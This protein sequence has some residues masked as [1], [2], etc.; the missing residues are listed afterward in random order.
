MNRWY[1]V[2]LMM[3]C[4]SCSNKPN[5]PDVSAIKAPISLQRFEQSFFT[6]DT[7]QMEESLQELTVE[8]HG[9]TQDFLFNILGSSPAAITQD[10]PVFIRTYQ[11]VAREIATNFSSLT[12]EVNEV[13][14]GLQFVKH[15]FPDYRLPEKII[16]FI[17]PLNSYGSIITQ[18]GLGIGLQLYMGSNHPLYL[19]EEGQQLYPRYISRRFDRKYIAVNAIKNIIDDLYPPAYGNQPL[20]AQMVE[21]GKR[22][23]LLDHLMPYE[24]DSIKTGYTQQQ[25]AGCFKNEKNIWSFFIQ[26]NLLFISDPEMI[27]DYMSEAPNTPTLG[28]AS[29]GFIGQFVGWQIVKK[30]MSQQK[31]PG[32][33]KMLMETPAKKI[34]EEAKYKP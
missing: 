29:P 10:I 27:R 33:M 8:Y 23:Y 18:D 20:F 13:Q 15:Y 21:A 14:Q 30:W 34:F 17:G 31:A 28:D 6:M 9:F 4:I 7:V 2:L 16:T 19:S 32:N 22:M 1:V 11:S 25:L 5:V 26:N 3:I 24:A 12:K